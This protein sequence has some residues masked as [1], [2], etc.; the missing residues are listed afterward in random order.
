MSDAPV[1]GSAAFELRATTDKLKSDLA[2]A[3]R[4]T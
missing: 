4:E 2:R 1:V 3:E